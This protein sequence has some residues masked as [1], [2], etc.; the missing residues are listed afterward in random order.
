MK[1]SPAYDGDIKALLLELETRLASQTVRLERNKKHF[2]MVSREVSII[3]YGFGT[4]SKAKIKFY[5]KIRVLNRG[6]NCF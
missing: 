6:A 4:I 3:K 2:S 5:D 1:K